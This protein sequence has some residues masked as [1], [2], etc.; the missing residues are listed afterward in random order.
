VILVKRIP[1][2]GAKTVQTGVLFSW[3]LTEFNYAD[4]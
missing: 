2:V 4:L 1:P 3:T